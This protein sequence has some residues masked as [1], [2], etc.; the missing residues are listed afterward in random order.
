M[1][2][3]IFDEIDEE[4]F[5]GPVNPMIEA[6]VAAPVVTEPAIDVKDYVM[7]KFNLGPYSDENRM[8]VQADSQLDWGDKASAALMGLGAAFQGK[9]SA[10]AA[11]N[12][13]NQL[14]SQ[15]R[16]GL[17]DFEKGRAAKNQEIGLD[18]QLT[19]EGRE[20]EEYARS[21]EKL[22][23]ELDPTSEES[24]MAQELARSMGYQGDTS[25]ITAKQF[26]DYSPVMAKKYEVEQRK[27]DRQEARAD[28]ADART[29]RQNEYDLRRDEVNQKRAETQTEKIQQLKT[30]YGVANTSE[31]AKQLKE[32][33]ESKLAFDGKIQEMIDLRKK[34]GGEMFNREAVARGKQLSKDLLLEYKNMAKLGVLSKSDE[35]IINAII[36]E[37]PLEYKVSSIVG[38]DPIMTKLTKFKQDSDRDFKTRVATRTR[39]GLSNYADNVSTK[40][41][42]PLSPKDQEAKKWADQNPNDPRATEIY[43]KLG[44]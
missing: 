42:S 23:R 12:R 10:S 8:Q 1:A 31:D 18:R 13:L 3:N 29:A 20:D 35:D 21:K 39:E 32:A 44:I 14:N 28:K 2:N 25:K 26:Q 9:D 34:Y 7:K 22:A 40:Q 38:Q 19:K 36:P 17:E 33:H 30:P 4:E 15:K 43:K 16:Q 11:S 37:D 5:Y 41:S 24:K 6:P 27:L